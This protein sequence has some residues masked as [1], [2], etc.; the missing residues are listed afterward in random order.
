M[1]YIKSTSQFGET[2]HTCNFII[3]TNS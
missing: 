1:F 3:R 2:V